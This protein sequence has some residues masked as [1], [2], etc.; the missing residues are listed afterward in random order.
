[1]PQ[2]A[3]LDL[4]VIEFENHRTS[5]V[6]LQDFCTA[7][8]GLIGLCPHA[9][10]AFHFAASLWRFRAEESLFQV[11]AISAGYLF[12]LDNF[13]A[14]KRRLHAARQ[15]DAESNTSASSDACE[16]AARLLD[17]ASDS[18]E[19]A[20]SILSQFFQSEVNPNRHDRN[21]ELMRRPGWID[22]LDSYCHALVKHGPIIRHW[23]GDLIDVLDQL[24]SRK[25]EVL[26]SSSNG[27]GRGNPLVDRL[28]KEVA[29]YQNLASQASVRLSEVDRERRELESLL[30]ERES[31]NADQSLELE[32]ARHALDV[33]L[34]EARKR[35]GD[36]ESSNVG[37]AADLNR[38]I[39]ELES[40]NSRL[41][42]ELLKTESKATSGA[43]DVEE[44]IEKLERAAD[45]REDAAKTI[46]N[47]SRRLKVVQEEVEVQSKQLVETDGASTEKATELEAAV[48]SL[49]LDVVR[50]ETDLQEANATIKAL[51][52]EKERQ[53]EYDDLLTASEARVLEAEDELEH[54][55]LRIEQLENVSDAKQEEIA[56]L[57]S[58]LSQRDDTITEIS[59]QL[60]ESETLTQ[61]HSGRINELESENERL[62]RDLS[63]AQGQMLNAKGDFEEAVNKER[64]VR[65]QV[66]R[67]MDQQKDEREERDLLKEELETVR[68]ELDALNE[69]AETAK[70]HGDELEATLARSSAEQ[71]E[72]QA[73]LIEAG[74]KLDAATNEVGEIRK[75]LEEKESV[76]SA[77]EASLGEKSANAEE[78][79][80]KS[81]EL[82]E[83]LEALQDEL[84]SAVTKESQARKSLVEFKTTSVELEQDLAV[85]KENQLASSEAA[86]DRE[87]KLRDKLEI[88]EGRLANS[89]K[90]KQTFLDAMQT[91]EN[92]RRDEKTELEAVI[93]KLRKESEDHHKALLEAQNQVDSYKSK[94]DESDSF[95]IERERELEKT[96]H[97]KKFFEEE[98][99]AIADLRAKFEETDK[100]SK[101]DELASQIS[102][103]MDGLF[104]EVGRPVHADR[105]TEKILVLHVKKSDE[106]IAAEKSSEFVATNA[107]SDSNDEKPSE[108]DSFE[109]QSTEE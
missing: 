21:I 42:D 91:G 13:I 50:T 55:S 60:A 90:E 104:T 12:E 49:R 63:D 59:S 69:L 17:N 28:K 56:D 3:I 1:M 14:A 95:V 79:A 10:A 25:P 4:P 45:E 9:D 99:R 46:E 39:K 2:Q 53:S 6:T 82:Q 22:D 58:K 88:L 52:S 36:L 94:L 89:V 16:N 29:D 24:A 64:D 32:D 107:D 27:N 73:K 7:S 8:Y 20:G 75:Q 51:E 43:V 5:L 57:E 71:D 105:R 93:N 31:G 47:L 109:A 108:N 40:E 66:T 92:S 98:V 26:A 97:R 77:A 68:L 78:L 70:A 18:L 72:L 35:L 85:A 41:A 19:D 15:N 38:R 33:T 23:R 106:E 74:E 67:M 83:E 76:L 62:R 101:R 37:E 44:L 11:A 65:A 103:R 61:G 54:S 30:S 86:Q 87:A 100:D 48:D 34:A 84:K 80:A 81:A 102:R 96:T